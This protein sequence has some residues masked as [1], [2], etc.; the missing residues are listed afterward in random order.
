MFTFWCNGFYSN[1]EREKKRIINNMNSEWCHVL[2]AM[3]Q[4]DLLN[5]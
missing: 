3:D 2:R 5:R 1:R 4:N